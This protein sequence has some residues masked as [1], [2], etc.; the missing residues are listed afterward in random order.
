MEVVRGEGGEGRGGVLR[1]R[2]RWFEGEVVK[3][4]VG[5]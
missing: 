3:E 2:W 1:V 5:C 4:R